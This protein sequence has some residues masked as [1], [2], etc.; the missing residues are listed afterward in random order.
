[1]NEALGHIA[2]TAGT[3]SVDLL[4]GR[5]SRSKENPTASTF[6]LVASAARGSRIPTLSGDLKV[7]E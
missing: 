4:F 3:F 2:T 6:R 1:M 7:E 5:G